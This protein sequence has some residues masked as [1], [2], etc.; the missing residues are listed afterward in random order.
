[1][2]ETSFT[3]DIGYRPALLDVVV[4]L[5]STFLNTSTAFCISSIVPMR[6]AAVRLLVGREV[7]SDH[8]A[9]GRGRR[10]GTR[11]RAA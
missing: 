11:R 10:R 8:D 4:V 7:A 3:L 9:G 6:D 5:P 1:M 2:A